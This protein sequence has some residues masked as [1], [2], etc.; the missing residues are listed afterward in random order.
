M[1]LLEGASIGF[2]ASGRNGGQV[3][4]GYACGIDTLSAQLGDGLARQMWDMSV[5]AVEII[6][7]RVSRHRIDCDWRRGYVSVAVKPRHMRELEDWQREAE[8]VYGYGGMQLW[9][10]AELGAR[11]ASE[12]YQGGLF[13]PRSGHLHPLNYTLGLA[14]AAREAGVAIYEQSPA[15]RLTRGRDRKWRPS[16]A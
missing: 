3:I 10:K 8:Q 7:Q 9:G 15:L 12:R 5:E 14:R 11:L 16:A 1:A 13:D 2:G 6:E 4:A